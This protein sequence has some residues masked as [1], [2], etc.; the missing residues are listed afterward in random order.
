MIN[1]INRTQFSRT[2]SKKQNKLSF[3]YGFERLAELKAHGLTQSL[4]EKTTQDIVQTSKGKGRTKTPEEGN[5]LAKWLLNTGAVMLNALKNN[6]LGTPAKS[7][8]AES[9]KKFVLPDSYILASQKHESEKTPMIKVGNDGTITPIMHFNHEFTA[10]EQVGETPVSGLT[11][12]VDNKDPDAKF[13]A[14]VTPNDK[15]NALRRIFNYYCGISPN[16]NE[17]PVLGGDTIEKKNLQIKFA[18][19]NENQKAL[20][21]FLD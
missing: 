15:E 16:P 20:N 7:L 9:C 11:P 8:T 6:S 10:D 17:K 21:L 2:N 3:G 14:I 1:S 12:V 18:E 13:F 19:D 5:I 4:I